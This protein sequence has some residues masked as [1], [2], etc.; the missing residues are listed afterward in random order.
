MFLTFPGRRCFN[1][2]L[3]S[4]CLGS[5][6]PAQ[7]LRESHQ[8]GD[9]K[10]MQKSC[11]FSENKNLNCSLRIARPV[12]GYLS[13]KGRLFAK[14][15]FGH[16]NPATGLDFSTRW[17]FRGYITLKPGPRRA[18]SGIPEHPNSLWV[19]CFAKLLKRAFIWEIFTSFLSNN[20]DRSEDELH[21]I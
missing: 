16:L 13:L 15:G 2:R 1:V 5:W 18:G 8:N 21:Q 7:K 11:P 19:M 6:L 10:S 20:F 9:Y 14:L 4:C 3:L 12:I 17:G